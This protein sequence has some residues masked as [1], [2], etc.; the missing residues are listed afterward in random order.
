MT[1]GVT[2]VKYRGRGLLAFL[3]PFYKCSSRYSNI[4]FLAPMFTAFVSIYNSTLVGDR[5]LVL[6]SHK[7]AFD[8]LSFFEMKLYPKLV[9]CLLDS[10][11]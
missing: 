5:I 10:L 7:E 4:F 9:A 8:G 1:C 3:E 2:M 11:S 6:G